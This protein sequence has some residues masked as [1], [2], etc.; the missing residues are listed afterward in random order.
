MTEYLVSRAD[1]TTVHPG[2]TISD[3]SGNQMRFVRA[4]GGVEEGNATLLVTTP[5]DY[6][7]HGME[8]RIGMFPDLRVTDLTKRVVEEVDARFD[9]P[10]SRLPED[11]P[12]MQPRHAA[13][14]DYVGKHRKAETAEEIIERQIFAG[15][16]S[17]A[18][19]AKY[20]ADAL[21]S[22]KLLA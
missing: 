21:R 8:L 16:S 9:V 10:L 4:L 5:L 11:Q 18:D 14:T 17:N 13:T 12:G 1:G 6:P 2:D 3:Y 19:L 20:I 7:D 15:A 22:A